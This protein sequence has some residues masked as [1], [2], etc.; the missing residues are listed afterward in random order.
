MSEDKKTVLVTG[1]ASGI[2]EA[3]CERLSEE[4]FAVTITDI[5]KSHS[6]SCLFYRCD[7]RKRRQINHL[8]DWVIK[9]IGVPDI[10]KGKPAV[11]KSTED[12]EK[13]EGILRINFPGYAEDNLENISWEEFFTIFD[14]NK[15]EFLYQKETKDGE[16]SRFNKF[17]NG[18]ERQE[19]ETRV[20]KTSSSKNTTEA[21]R[22]RS[23]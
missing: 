17:V 15:L 21:R 19:Q 20:V 3:I 1:G 6:A 10:L 18:F 11:V 8:Y 13:G 7:V 2:G 4:G 12:T 9:N 14:E 22:T 23:V 5:Q 16:E